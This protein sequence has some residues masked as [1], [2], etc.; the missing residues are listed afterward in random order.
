MVYTSVLIYFYNFL[1]PLTEEE[2]AAIDAAGAK[3]PPRTFH[4]VKEHLFNLV[5]RE[6]LFTNYLALLAL[7]ALFLVWLLLV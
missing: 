7:L 6:L 2:I 3:G 5:R 1:A 4:S